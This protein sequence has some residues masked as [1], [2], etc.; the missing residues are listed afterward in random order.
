MFCRK[1]GTETPDDSQF[2]QK[3]ALDEVFA[4]GILSSLNKGGT[5][6]A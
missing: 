3:C 4:A 5:Y 1:C 2:C 6:V